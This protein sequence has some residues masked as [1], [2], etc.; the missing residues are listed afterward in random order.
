[1]PNRPSFILI[2]S[3]A[4]ITGFLFLSAD[5]GPGLWTAAWIS[6]IVCIAALAWVA[7]TAI[8]E[9]SLRDMTL[10]ITITL[11]L[12]LSGIVAGLMNQLR[13]EQLRRD[14]DTTFAL[15]DESILTS[16]VRFSMLELFDAHR[17]SDGAVGFDEL[18]RSG[19]GSIDSTNIKQF[20]SIQITESSADRVVFTA[21]TRHSILFIG[22]VTSEGVRYERQN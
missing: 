1:M 16:E 10:P 12:F 8:R 11:L 2:A 15:V 13:N 7:R 14:M 9:T 22:T 4:A 19:I 3:A 5:Q 17:Q 21:Q 18:M 6:L 20:G